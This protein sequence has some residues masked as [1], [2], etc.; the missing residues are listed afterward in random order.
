M[1]QIGSIP[2]AAVRKADMTLLKTVIID[3]HPGV[4]RCLRAM[5]ECEPAVEIVG[6]A[7]NGVLALEAVRTLTPDLLLLDINMPE[8]TG[9]EVL[10]HLR[11]ARNPVSVIIL[12]GHADSRYVEAA[13]QLGA[14][15]YVGKESGA[16]VLMAA[17]QSVR[18]GVAYIDPN[19]SMAA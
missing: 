15:G 2:F 4:R 17:I 19:I 9:L 14:N 13:L 12:S 1:M 5:M 18:S 8:M 3:D 7:G 11:A 10:K 6:E 16:D